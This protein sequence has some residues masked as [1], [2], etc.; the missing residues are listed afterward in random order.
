MPTKIFSANIIIGS[1]SNQ[2]VLEKVAVK[3]I[4]TH[5]LMSNPDFIDWLKKKV[6]GNSKTDVAW[7]RLPKDKD[8]K[9]PK[10]KIIYLKYLSQTG[11]EPELPL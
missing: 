10:I 9:L 3:R 8:T 4:P 1:D 11:S 5:L 6:A 7:N 2:F